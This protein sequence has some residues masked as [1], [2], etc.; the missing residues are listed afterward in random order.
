[1]A[2]IVSANITA[3]LDAISN[4]DEERIIAETLQLLGPEKVPPAKVTARVGIPAVWAGGEGHP[5][6]LLSVAGRVA[7][8]MRSIPIGP[9]PESERRRAL[10][11]A[12]PLIQ[13]F[14]AVSEQVR[15]GLPEPHP[16]LPDPI[17]PADV[18]HAGGALGAL[19]EAVSRRDLERTRA[20]LMGYYATG[21]DYRAVLT[22]IYAALD[23]H[24]PDGGHPLYFAVS[25]TRLLDMADWGD[26]MP[27]YLYWVTPLMLD[28][29][30]NAAPGDAAAAYAA[31]A[32]HDLGWLRNRLSIP[33]PEAAGSRFQQ[34]LVAGDATAAC[35]AL[36]KAL[37]DGATPMDA[38][39]GM[40]LAA[41]GQVNAVPQG[42]TDALMRAAHVLL[43]THAVH[44]A[45]QHTQNPEIW[46]LLYTAACAVN[47]V[48]A[49]GSAAELERGASSVSSTAA[50]GLIPT[51]MLRKL[52]Q[53]LE[54]GDT[55]SA[56]AGA[57]RYLQM[58]HPPRALAGIIGSAAATRDV[59]QGQAHTLHT[60]P[61]VAAAAEE[62]LNLPRALASDGQ[63]ALLVAAIRL[64]SELQSGHALA[65]RVRAAISAR[66]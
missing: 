47:S 53:Q 42:D 22:A 5:I 52:E 12:L 2:M 44:V 43:Y 14:V 49:S 7:E 35:D 50:G 51:S 9:E 15:K 6:S 32:E 17:V 23:F 24:Y 31:A 46:P 60:L 26:R 45:T 61:L 38:A 39:S 34:A 65:D 66:L 48:R 18:N 27:A 36:L 37:R 10:A 57:R 33:K 55:A 62:Y 54:E 16:T 25:A 28:A 40:A 58:G 30:P 56:L 1:M 59:Q 41:A 20:I 8:W 63:N 4:A 29:A 64:A 11:P 3:L 19:R 21:T 13:A